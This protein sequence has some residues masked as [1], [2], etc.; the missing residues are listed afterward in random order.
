MSKRKSNRIRKA[1][2]APRL[3]VSALDYLKRARALN[4]YEHTAADEIL[5]AHQ[6][7]HGLQVA[8]DPDLG[9]PVTLR[10]DGAD[11]AAARRMDVV[12]TYH[13]WL[14]DMR[15]SPPLIAV[16]AVVLAGSSFRS[17]DSS[18]QWR[19]GSAKTHL[20]TGLRHFAAL[21]GNIPRGA[22]DWKVRRPLPP[23]W[24]SWAA[25]IEWE[26]GFR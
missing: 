10:T 16:Q 21:R 24:L 1:P 5:M 15:G 4:V 18:M 12:K 3:A 8:R 25:V 11:D 14:R 26:R 20:Y 13:N 22:Y 2:T 6:I 17:V 9:L 23:Q 7:D 19:K